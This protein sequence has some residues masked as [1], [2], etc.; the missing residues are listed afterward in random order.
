MKK[1]F[2][3]FIV[4]VSA[5]SCTLDKGSGTHRTP[6]ALYQYTSCLLYD[7]VVNSVSF[8]DKSLEIDAYLG[9]SEEEKQKP[10]YD[11]LRQSLR[12][13][14]ENTFQYERALIINTDGPL[15]EQ[16]TVWTLELDDDMLYNYMFQSYYW[17]VSGDSDGSPAPDGGSSVTWRVECTGSDSWKISAG[18]DAVMV[19]MEA[20][21]ER[22][23]A[24]IMEGVK[25]EGTGY[26]YTGKVSGQIAED[27]DGTGAVFRTE[28][29]F[30]YY[31]R[32]Y[33]WDSSGSDE[34]DR[35]YYHDYDV[36]FRLDVYRQD[37]LSD[38]CELTC[39]SD[40]MDCQTSLGS[41]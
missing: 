17:R 5:V 22:A 6:D 18:G 25:Y 3:Y 7:W 9:L 14:D 10:E 27:P 4:S 36:V 34:P 37:E 40:G 23:P 1:I 24:D 38:W 8:L 12:Q 19:S 26:D 39:S 35:E 28:S 30:R 15:T 20:D 41:L 21:F 31:Y 29:D 13:M 2:L 11:N 33:E 32:L 16:G